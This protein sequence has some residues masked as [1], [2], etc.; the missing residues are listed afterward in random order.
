MI[1]TVNL[2]VGAIICSSTLYPL[3]IFYRVINSID[4]IYTRDTLYFIIRH[5]QNVLLL[6]S[7]EVWHKMK[8]KIDFD[9]TMVRYLNK[10]KPKFINFLNLRSS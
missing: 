1:E 8:K 5:V 7:F 4:N 2:A 3:I 10:N 6:Q 9:V